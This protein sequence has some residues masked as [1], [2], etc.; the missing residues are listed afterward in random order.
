M[1]AQ[2]VLTIEVKPGWKKGTKVIFPEKGNEQSGM[3]P[4]DLVFLIDERP[5]E[6]FHREGH[7]LVSIQRIPLSDAL[8][9]Y[10]VSLT[11]CDGRILHIPCSDIIHPGYEKVVLKE[12]MPIAREPGKKGNLRIKFDVMF[13][14]RLTPEQKTAIRK[15]LG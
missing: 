8:V 9:G 3:V 4:A 12:G 14:T 6:T 11:T 2:E 10:N 5:H 1:P 7:D 15:V 13:P